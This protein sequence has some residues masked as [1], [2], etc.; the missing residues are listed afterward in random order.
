METFIRFT[1]NIFFSAVHCVA[2]VCLTFSSFVQDM[3]Y[4]RMSNLSTMSGFSGLSSVTGDRSSVSSISSTGTLGGISFGGSPDSTLKRN[5]HVYS[6]DDLGNGNDV[7]DDN[8]LKRHTC[9]AES[10]LRHTNSASLPDLDPEES[11]KLYNT[12]V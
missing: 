11:F 5:E 12:P 10:G 4:K 1:A 8:T 2:S 6:R 3:K 7:F 9:T